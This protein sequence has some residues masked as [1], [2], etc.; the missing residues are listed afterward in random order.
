MMNK[1]IGKKYGIKQML[2]PTI[3]FASFALCNFSIAQTPTQANDTVQYKIF[4]AGDQ[5]KKSSFHQKVWGKNYRKEWTEPVNIPTLNL[6]STFGKLTLI[7]K[8]E[9]DLFLKTREAIT[10]G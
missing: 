6:N 5:F 8:K 7:S 1:F 9:N 10:T 4:S 2:H 3:L